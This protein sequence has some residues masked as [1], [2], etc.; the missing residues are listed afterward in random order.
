MLKNK[1]ILLVVSGGVAAYKALDLVR[2][3]RSCDGLV[4]CILTQSGSN[5]VTPLSLQA[6]SESKVYSDLFSLTDES[7]MGHIQ[8]SRN[9]DL[10]VVAPAS[11]NFLA[12]MRAGICDD[13]GS[14][15]LLA[16]DKPVLVAPSMNV[17]MWEHAATMEN[18]SVLKSRGINVV[19][20]SQ[21]PM[22][23]GETGW[24]RM[25]EPTEI[26]TAINALIS[27]DGPLAGKRAL[28]T[29]GPT[30]EPIDP[31]RYI[32]NR[33]SG[34]QGYAIASALSAAGAD[35]TLVTGPTNIPRPNGVRIIETE[36]AEEMLSC[37]ME[38][39]PTHVAVCAAA[40]AD[41][42]VSHRSSQKMKKNSDNHEPSIELNLNPDILKTLSSAGPNRPSLVVGFAAETDNVIQNGIDKRRNKGCD[43]I[44]ANDVS[45]G[46]GTFGGDNNSIHFISSG[47]PEEWPCMP[48]EHV[49]AKLTKKIASEIGK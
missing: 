4:H 49:A 11:A 17:R 30:W 1:R 2:Q 42:K 16:T 22:A 24:G 21:G 5:F 3:I 33:S 10:I 25:A 20:P 23:C 27:S 14:T 32:A 37:C 7:E 44:L 18:I 8:L 26:I 45:V 39:L 43:W 28:V 9:V 29:A 48:K 40:V 38:A 46:T 35:T 19:G 36:T 41:W 31:V 12:K 6:L 34:K 47:E 13:L 15:V